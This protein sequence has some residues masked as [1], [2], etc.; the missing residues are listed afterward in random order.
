LELQNFPQEEIRRDREEHDDDKTLKWLDLLEHVF[1]LNRV[2][3]L[4]SLY[5]WTI[6]QNLISQIGVVHH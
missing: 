2:L 3:S 4:T 6:L 1:G 5:N